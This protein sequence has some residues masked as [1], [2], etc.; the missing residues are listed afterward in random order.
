M[1]MLNIS[2]WNFSKSGGAAAGH[3]PIAPPPPPA[4][5][6]QIR[7]HHP[8]HHRHNQLDTGSATSRSA[9]SVGGS[10]KTYSLRQED[11]FIYSNP[12]FFE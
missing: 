12:L 8:H 10:G 4:S 11:D 2:H 5:A 9:D 6:P 7:G 3:G 1:D